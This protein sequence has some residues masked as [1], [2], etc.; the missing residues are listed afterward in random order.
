MSPNKIS[1]DRI[2]ILCC[3]GRGGS[4]IVWQMIGSSPDIVMTTEE[5]HVA[6]FGR[7]KILRKTIR[8]AFNFLHVQSFEPLRRHALRRT[9]A[10]R[11]ANDLSTK[12]EAGSFVIKLM[13][14]QLVFSEMIRRSFA[15]AVFVILARHP[16][17][18]CESLIRSGL[19]L[20]EACE[21]YN[22]VARMMVARAKSAHAV[23]VHFEDVVT[24]PIETC[25]SL[26]RQLGV[27]WAEDKRF[28]FKIKP[29]GRR[30]TSEVDVTHGKIIRVGTEDVANYIDSSVLKG[31]RDRLSDAQ[32]KSIWH[33]TG[34]AAMQLGYSKV[35]P[36]GGC[37]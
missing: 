7:N 29:Y 19:G 16:Y 13:D 33:L 1:G 23:I 14:Y 6:V 32:R 26:Y 18:Q 30:R 34:T 31:E 24:R 8:R 12:K 35:S 27:R 21:W 37:S 22:N 17:G 20:R 2:I 28:N 10:M 3:F 36:H 11:D 5:W 4:S 9:L 15:K 25:E